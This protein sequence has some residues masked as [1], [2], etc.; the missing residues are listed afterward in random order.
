MAAALPARYV[1]IHYRVRTA[2]GD[3][4]TEGGPF[5]ALRRIA[6]QYQ[7]AQDPARYTIGLLAFIHIGI[8]MGAARGG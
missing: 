3:F 2:S 8:S 7:Q 5:G 4:N 1:L 6:R